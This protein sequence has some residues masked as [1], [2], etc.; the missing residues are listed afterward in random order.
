MQQ[1]LA[2]I[3]QRGQSGARVAIGL[4]LLLVGGF[5][6]YFVWLLIAKPKP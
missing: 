4:A 6:A 5:I 3:G 2:E 1:K